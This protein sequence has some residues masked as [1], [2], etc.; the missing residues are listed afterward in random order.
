[1]ITVLYILISI[2]LINY[3][4][5]HPKVRKRVESLT[6]NCSV[7]PSI[8]LYYYY[9]VARLVP[10]FVVILF[11]TLFTLVSI[12]TTFLKKRYHVHPIRNSLIRY[13]AWWAFQ[14]FL[15]LSCCILYIFPLLYIIG[16]SLLLIN[17]FYLIRESRRL[18]YILRARISD[19]VNYEWDPVR[20]KPSK[21]AYRIYVIFNIL[22]IVSIFFH[23]F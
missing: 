21:L 20:Y 17:Y 19:I 16:P 14:V 10:V 22:Y 1:M 11:C 12:L 5:Q 4:T 3:T 2:P 7:H 18:A 6:P 9:P 15:L 23:T 13:A 8:G